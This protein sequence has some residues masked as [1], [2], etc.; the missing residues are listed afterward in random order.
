MDIGTIIGLIVAFVLV[1]GSIVLGGGT[2]FFNIPAIMVTI[3]G[4][5]GATL[6]NFPL[7]KIVSVI[8]VVRK[9]FLSHAQDYIA[10]YRRLTDFGT[11]ARRDGLLSLEDEVESLDDDFLQKGFRMAIDGSSA[12]FIRRILDNDIDAMIERHSVG[13]G[14]FKALGNY[15]PAFG[16][17]G[18]LIGLV[19]MLRN[20]EDPSQIGMGMAVALLT[21]LYGAL[22]A[23]LVALP[24]AGKLEQRSSEEIAMKNM[25]MEGI[26]AIQQGDSPAVIRQKLRS[27]MAPKLRKLIE[28]EEK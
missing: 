7:P 16:M 11:R 4:S 8:G 17:I 2:G 13:Q 24:I 20:L 21:T 26:L 19:Q 23:N 9:A 28:S 22:V 18:T 1:I 27:F 14:I 25:V 12:D 15:A 6:I 5:F 10:Q 3:G